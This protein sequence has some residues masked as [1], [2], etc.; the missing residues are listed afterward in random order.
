MICG[1]HSFVCVCL[2]RGDDASYD[3]RSHR[4]ITHSKCE[5]CFIS[6]GARDARRW[7]VQNCFIWSHR[8]SEG[9]WSTSSCNWKRLEFVLRIFVLHRIHE[10]VLENEYVVAI[11]RKRHHLCHSFWLAGWRCV[12]FRRLIGFGNTNRMKMDFSA[13]C[14]FRSFIQMKLNLNER[15]HE[16]RF[17]FVDEDFQ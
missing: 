12:P 10:S 14:L 8:Y 17:S 11:D 5:N 13:K 2:N 3:S 15:L 6:F 1:V 7:D 4:L 9:T 16:I